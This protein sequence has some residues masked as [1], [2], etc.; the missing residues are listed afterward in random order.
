MAYERF[1]RALGEGIGSPLG[2]AVCYAL[3]WFV[4]VGIGWM[5]LAAAG[6]GDSYLRGLPTCLFLSIFSFSGIPVGLMNMACLACYIR[7]ELSSW[8]LL[9]PFGSYC[10]LT[11][12]LG[13]ELT[14]CPY[15]L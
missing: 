14:E 6:T 5:A 13:F 2:R 3:S 9:L 10:G 1:F 15:I 11:L 7:L 4:G 8:W 12:Y